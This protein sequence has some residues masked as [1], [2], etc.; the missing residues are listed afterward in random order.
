M[1]SQPLVQVFAKL[2]KMETFVQ[3]KALEV[4][5]KSANRFIK[6]IGYTSLS[7]TKASSPALNGQLRLEAGHFLSRFLRLRECHFR[8]QF[9]N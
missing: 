8:S 7:H 2:A 3:Q 5:S 6:S 9:V 4:N 1:A